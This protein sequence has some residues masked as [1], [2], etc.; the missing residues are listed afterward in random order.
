M[1]NGW[2]DP[3]FAFWN[4][5]LH[6]QYIAWARLE[7]TWQDCFFVIWHKKVS[8]RVKWLFD[9]LFQCICVAMSVNARNL[10]LYCC[11]CSHPATAE[12]ETR[13]LL[14]PSCWERPPT[15]QA[16]QAPRASDMVRPLPSSGASKTVMPRRKVSSWKLRCACLYS[17][18]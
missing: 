9:L 3:W 5:H 8:R 10:I 12:A 17:C 14:V 15:L 7:S 2:Q 6:V 13:R 4:W 11:C 1:F 18:D 16:A